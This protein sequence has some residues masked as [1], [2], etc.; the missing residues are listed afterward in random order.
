[1]AAFGEGVKK[2]VRLRNL[3]S[4]L[5]TNFSK[6]LKFTTVRGFS[7]V[8]F[9]PFVPF[10]PCPPERSSQEPTRTHPQLRHCEG[11][12]TSRGNLSV[13]SAP[14]A[15]TNAKKIA[16]IIFNTRKRGG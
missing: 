3:R 5:L 6:F 4:T 7:S 1:M 15:H 12:A 10:V 16:G 11:L 13:V 14:T 8:P 2:L 9:V